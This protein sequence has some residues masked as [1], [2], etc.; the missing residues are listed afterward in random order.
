[1]RW[2]SLRLSD[3]TS[4]GGTS[5]GGTANE[6]LF[7]RDAV[8]TRTFDTPGFRADRAHTVTDPDYIDPGTGELIKL[9]I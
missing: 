8:V 6:A 3:D 1:M 5:N 7:S 4:S 9:S 2:D